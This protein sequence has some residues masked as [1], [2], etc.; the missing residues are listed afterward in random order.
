MI[1][2]TVLE[3]FEL[4]SPNLFQIQQSTKTQT[5]Q[6]IFRKQLETNATLLKRKP[7][8]QQQRPHKP[9]NKVPVRCADLVASDVYGIEALDSA[10]KQQAS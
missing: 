7:P 10:C 8:Q 6:T 5:Y 1:K 4:Q 2:I 9:Q 3:H